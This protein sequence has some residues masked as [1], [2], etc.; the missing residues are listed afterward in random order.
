MEL[1]LSRC[2]VLNLEYSIRLGSFPFRRVFC[3]AT[4]VL[5]LFTLQPWLHLPLSILQKAC[6]LHGS[7]SSPSVHETATARAC[8]LPTISPQPYR[9]R[10]TSLSGELSQFLPLIRALRHD[11]PSGSAS[12]PFPLA[13]HRRTRKSAAEK[14]FLERAWPRIREAS[15][16][17]DDV[18]RCPFLNSDAANGA[19]SV[20]RQA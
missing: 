1:H 14:Q 2:K 16:K 10:T 6:P 19:W 9:P 5:P 12:G 18:F 13:N 15:P 8:Q 11:L 4:F 7:V 3:I 20:V 17:G